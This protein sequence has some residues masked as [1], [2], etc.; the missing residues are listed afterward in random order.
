MQA[1]SWRYVGESLMVREQSSN[2][3]VLQGGRVY[4]A[5]RKW[6]IDPNEVVDF[7]ANIN[8]YGPPRGVARALSVSKKLIGHYPDLSVLIDVISK[9]V[10]VDRECVTIG[11]GSTALIFAAIRALRPKRALL[12]EPA[13][14]EY[15]RG[16]QSVQTT[17][18]TFQLSSDNNFLPDWPALNRSLATGGYDLIVINN[19]HNPSGA[20]IPPEKLYQFG[21]RAKSNNTALVIDEAFIDYAPESSTIPTITELDNVIV[22]RSLTKF[23]SMPGL[24]VGYAVCHPNLASTLQAQIESWPVSNTA[25]S[26]AVVALNDKEFDEFSREQNLDIYDLFFRSLKELD[27][28]RAF[29]SAANYILVKVENR[30]CAQFAK[31]LES[32]HTLIRLCDSFEGLGPEYMRLA[33]RFGDEVMKLFESLVNWLEG[34]S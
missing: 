15:R 13:F 12:L 32:S 9:K 33:V 23:Y 8:P 18:E 26:A 19:P 3:R 21:L 7:S 4:E 11:N 34:S 20:L 2:E 5:A 6:G 24:R 22:L 28:V 17:I 16:L 31:E 25:I 14:A 29:P 30:D 1:A 27:G 10:G